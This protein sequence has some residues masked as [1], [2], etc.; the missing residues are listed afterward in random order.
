MALWK[1]RAL[2]PEQKEGMLEEEQQ[3]DEEG[4]P[5]TAEDSGL[6]FVNE[7]TKLSKIYSAELPIN[8]RCL[9]EYSS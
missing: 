3:E 8:V 6:F 1:T 7:D 2:T 4:R 5:I 9:L